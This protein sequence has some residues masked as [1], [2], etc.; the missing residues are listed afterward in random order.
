ME[1]KKAKNFPIPVQL[2]KV[3][4][5]DVEDQVR[6]IG[7]ILEEK[8][9]VLSSEIEGKIINIPFR[10]GMKVKTNDI[11]AQIDPRDFQLEVD[12]LHHAL[13]SASEELE[14][15]QTGGSLDDYLR[16]IAQAVDHSLDIY[17]EAVAQK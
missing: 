9:V 10:E 16:L 11:L 4:Y 2:G 12:R 13:V 8:R 3:V 17:L 15:A 5:R 6:T 7:V 14:K 1:T